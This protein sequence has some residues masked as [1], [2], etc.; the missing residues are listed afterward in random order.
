MNIKFPLLGAALLVCTFMY[1]QEIKTG[2]FGKGIFNVTGKD[3]TFTMKF[4]VRFQLLGV[5][6]WKENQPND[7]S[8]LVRRSRLKLDGFVYSPKLKYKFEAGFSNRDMS[9]GSDD[10]THG[11]PRFI[12]DAFVDWNFYKNMI[13]RVGQG[14][15][16]GNRERII[17][18]ANLQLVDR[19][20]LNSKFNIDRDIGFQLKHFFNPFGN[21]YFREILS[22]SLGEGR[23]VTSGNLGGLQYVGGIEILPFGNFQ[24]KGDYKGA[25][26]KR[27]PTPKLAI[28]ASYEFNNDAVRTRSNLGRYMFID[29][30]NGLYKT[31]INTVFIDAMFKYKGYSFMFEYA[32]R[33]ADDPFAKN[34]DGSL[35]GDIIETGNALNFQSG[36]LFASNWEIAGRYTDLN[37]NTFTMQNSKD[38]YTLGVSKYIVGHKLKIQ[39][40]ISYIETHGGSN[41]ILARLQMD[42]HF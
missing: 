19:S 42:V 10:F 32:D 26:L 18:S 2:A 25:D 6:S 3:S 7:L 40:D 15:L 20:L 17:S 14:K 36:Y 22:I 21:L 16:P 23:N 9:G 8:F 38:M 1:A 35:T 29:S 27:E 30:N 31:D 4:A 28:A 5:S 13:I 39:S 12:M 33:N 24:S 37:M 34:S 11:S 41:E